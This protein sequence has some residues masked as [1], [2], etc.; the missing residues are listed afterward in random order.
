MR[1]DE[2]FY[3]GQKEAAVGSGKLRTP[4]AP[5]EIVEVTTKSPTQATG[6]TGSPLMFTHANGKVKPTAVKKFTDDKAP[7]K[8]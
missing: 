4:I 6:I 5:G 1:I 8:K 7:A 2:Y 3:N